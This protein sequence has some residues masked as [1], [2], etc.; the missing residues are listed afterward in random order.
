MTIPFFAAITFP[1]TVSSLG[2]DKPQRLKA[3][4]VLTIF[5]RAT[6]GSV[7]SG[8]RLPGQASSQLMTVVSQ[9]K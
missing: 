6:T 9:E 7:A 5:R 2:M 1:K 4:A 3:D 8:K